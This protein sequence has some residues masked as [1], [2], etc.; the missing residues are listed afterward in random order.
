MLDL[1]LVMTLGFLGSFG[2][3]VGMCG[4]LTLGVAVL[5]GQ[6]GAAS[7]PESSVSPS[8]SSPGPRSVQAQFW[9]QLQFHSLLNLGRLLSYTLV[10]AGMGGVGSVLIASGQFAGIDS[11]LRQSLSLITG[12]LLIWMG[13]VQ[14]NP[15]LWPQLPLPHAF[16]SFRLNQRLR[17]LAQRGGGWVPLLLGLTWGLIP[18][19]FLYAAQVKA[20]GTG[21]FELGAATMLA[22]G[23]GTVPAMLGLGLFANRLS[24]DHR[25]Q[26]F[27]LGSWVLILL[28]GL[29]L[30]RTESMGIDLTGH[31]AI[32]FW[33]LALVARPLGQVWPGLRHYRRLLG[34]S[35]F[36]LALLHSLQMLQ[37]TLHWNFAAIQFMPLEQAWALWAGVIALVLL[38]PAALTSFDRMVQRLGR[39]WRRL[40]LLTVPGV[41]FALAHTLKLGSS[42]LNRPLLTAYNWLAVTLLGAVVILVL[43]IRCRWF[44]SIWSLEKFYDPQAPTPLPVPPAADPPG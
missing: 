18:C 17:Y 27:R 22:F 3:C 21:R 16:A 9:Q 37:H 42:Y 34:V 43:L 24:A 10:G 1:L 2:H 35:A 4:P 40:H 44:W 5:A 7:S 28:G 8:T 29:T 36:V 12:G 19:G 15:R 31:G 39:Y 6:Q 38:L 23:L 26:L 33:L 20:A 11:A 13:L 32:L 14:L 41:I 30:L 25:S